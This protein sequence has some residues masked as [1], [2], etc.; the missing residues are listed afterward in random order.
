MFLVV[1]LALGLLYWSVFMRLLPVTAQH[2]DKALEMTRLAD[3]LEQL[4]ARWT[5]RQ[6]E[7]TKARF[8]RLQANLF[9]PARDLADWQVQVQEQARMR[10]LDARLELGPLQPLTGAATGISAMTA[11]LNLSP[12]SV[13]GSAATPYSR[14]LR[15]TESLAGTSKRLELLELNVTGDS[16]SVS[17]AT[18][19]V[20]LYAAERKAL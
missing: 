15:F 12:N 19:V 9:D 7:E 11:Q 18:A 8:E 10:V 1:I 16:N 17:H 2:R 5:P 6:I 20:Q 3:E 4:R 14:L 13:L